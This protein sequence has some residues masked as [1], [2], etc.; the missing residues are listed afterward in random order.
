MNERETPADVR[1]LLT[2]RFG[3]DTILSVATT[4]NGLPH[5]RQVNAYYED[6]AFYVVTYARSAKMRQIAA[7]P[8]VAVCGEW[9]TAHGVGENRGHILAPENAEMAARLRT[10][11]AAWYGNGHVNEADTN[12]CILRIRLTDGVLFH[13]GTR[14]AFDFSKE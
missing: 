12:T 5:V 10:A 8:R 6:G 7:Q 4:E 3:H 14:Y 9:F 11:F 13:H 1:D 2:E